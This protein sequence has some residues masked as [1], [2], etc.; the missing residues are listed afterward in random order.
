M[1]H[2]PFQSCAPVPGTWQR[3]G[4]L[5]RPWCPATRLLDQREMD[6]LNGKADA[7]KKAGMTDSRFAEKQAPLREGFPPY[8]V[9]PQLQP[10]VQPAASVPA[11]AAV[12]RLCMH[13]PG[14]MCLAQMLP[15]TTS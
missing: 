5:V 8:E 15:R 4:R 1:H 6:A 9:T 10:R 13:V 14:P 2:I 12:N 3:M 7:A 11:D